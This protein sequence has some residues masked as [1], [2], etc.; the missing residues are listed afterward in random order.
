VALSQE[1]LGLR[2]SLHRTEIGLLERGGRV[3][4]IDTFLKLTGS[5]ECDPN[6]LLSG[7]DWNPAGTGRGQFYVK[8][9]R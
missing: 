8:G 4:R 5:L 1:A 7:I 9:G 6:T 2:A 3:P